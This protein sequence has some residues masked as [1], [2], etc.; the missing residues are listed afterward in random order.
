[1]RGRWQADLGWW[2]EPLLWPG[3]A[4]GACA[5]ALSSRCAL[6]AM[7]AVEHVRLTVRSACDALADARRR[8]AVWLLIGLIDGTVSEAALGLRALTLLVETTVRGLAALLRVDPPAVISAGLDGLGHA[9]E[10]VG[11]SLRVLCGFAA[12]S[13]C[14]R[15]AE[16]RR[17]TPSEPRRTLH[18]DHRVLAVD[19]AETNLWALHGEGLINLYDLAGVPVPAFSSWRPR[20]RAPVRRLN[21]EGRSSWRPVTRAWLRDHIRSFGANGR[22]VWSGADALSVRDGLWTARRILEQAGVSLH[23]CRPLQPVFPSD[24]GGAGDRIR[25][26]MQPMNYARDW[27]GRRD[28]AVTRG[29]FV[30]HALSVVVQQDWGTARPVERSL[31]HDTIGFVTYRQGGPRWL[32]CYI[33]A[34][35]IGH[36]LGLGHEGRAFNEVMWSP[37]V[38]LRN[39]LGPALWRFV[40]SGDAGFRPEDVQVVRQRLSLP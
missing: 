19:S 20:L 4:L 37:V 11:S 21:A 23:W 25:S 6:L 31:S 17:W 2:C 24:L 1:M 28:A 30:V 9:F 3:M 18:C 35:E 40:L 8:G 32:Q 33:L 27:P 22:L 34:H 29:A 36:C 13:G 12:M 26:W 7:G 16:R 15:Q 38:S 10:A 14:L 5:E 39:G